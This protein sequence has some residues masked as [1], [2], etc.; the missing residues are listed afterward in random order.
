MKAIL[1]DRQHTIA[2]ASGD[3]LRRVLNQLADAPGLSRYKPETLP[4]ERLVIEFE[5]NSYETGIEE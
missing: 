5:E 2:E 3:S 4:F 1:H